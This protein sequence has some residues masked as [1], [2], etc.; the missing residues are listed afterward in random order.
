MLCHNMLFSEM[1]PKLFRYYSDFI[2]Q[3]DIATQFDI[4]GQHAVV[5]T[6][7]SCTL[8]QSTVVSWQF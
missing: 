7:L 5:C 4:D 1:G 2:D 8:G 6:V 3:S